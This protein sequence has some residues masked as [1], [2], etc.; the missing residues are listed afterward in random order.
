MIGLCDCHQNRST[1]IIGLV[2]E[3]SQKG[4]HLRSVVVSLLSLLFLQL[5]RDALHRTSLDAPHQTSNIA[6]DLV[7]HAFCWNLGDV[8][9]DA[10]VGVEVQRQAWIVSLDDSSRRFLDGFGTNFTLFGGEGGK[11]DEIKL[12]ITTH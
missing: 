12:V 10:F 2:N 8:I 11:K 7:S 5:D 6:G 3:P 1:Q 9:T 4:T